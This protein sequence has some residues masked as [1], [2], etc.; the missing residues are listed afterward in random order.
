MARARE[1]EWTTLTRASLDRDAPERNADRG[2]GRQGPQRDRSASTML[3]IAAVRA[4]VRGGLCCAVICVLRAMHGS[5][6]G[7]IRCGCRSLWHHRRRDRR[8]RLEQENEYEQK[9]D[10]GSR[11]FHGVH[12]RVTPNVTGFKRC[13]CNRPPSHAASSV[14]AIT[15]RATAALGHR[16]RRRAKALTASAPIGA[17]P[18]FGC[19][20]VATILW[21]R[22]TGQYCSRCRAAS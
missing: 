4:V 6:P 19:R 11:G 10:E 15:L 7:L 22:A 20:S 2:C 17:P 18:R 5:D 16:P 3:R 14:T 8:S 1:P 21:S 13:T 12:H 9:L